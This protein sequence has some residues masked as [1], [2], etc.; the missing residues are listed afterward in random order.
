M[1]GKNQH[2]I[3]QSLLRGFSFPRSSKVDQLFVFWK[4]RSYPT[5][6]E[7]AAM[8][9]YFYSTLSTDGTE[10]LDDRITKYENSLASGLSELRK[11]TDQQPAPGAVVSEIIV[12]LTIRSAY[13]RDVFSV[14]YREVAARIDELSKDPSSWRKFIDIDGLELPASILSEIDSNL[15]AL[16][17]SLPITVPKHLLA[18]MTHAYLR[19]NFDRLFGG[20]GHLM[21]STMNHLLEQSRGM[22]RTGH[23]KALE[24]DLV[25]QQQQARLT[26]F[27]WFCVAPAGASF[28]LPDC[29]ALAKGRGDTSLHPFLMN[30]IDELEAVYFPIS[31]QQL[32]VGLIDDTP[33]YVP[34]EFNKMAAACSYRS[35]F[36]RSNEDDIRA[37]ATLIGSYV[38]ARIKP[39]ITESIKDLRVS[40]T[41]RTN[42]ATRSEESYDAA[43][44]LPSSLPIAFE[45]CDA[46]QNKERIAQTVGQIVHSCAQLFPLERLDQIVFRGDYSTIVE[47]YRLQTYQFNIRDDDGGAQHVHVNLAPKT[48]VEGAQRSFPIYPAELAAQL[49][50][51]EGD[52]PAHAAIYSIAFQLASASHREMLDK[53]FPGF[54][55]KAVD[56]Q[57]DA[58][59]QPIVE[60]TLTLYF[61]AR[62]CTTVLPAAVAGSAEACLAQLIEA[63]NQIPRLRREYFAVPDMQ[64]LLSSI[65]DHMSRVFEYSA[66]TLGHSR[67]AGTDLLSNNSLLESSFQS[68][69]LI[70]WIHVFA[71]DLEKAFQDRGQWKSSGDFLIFQQHIERILWIFGVIFWHEESGEPRVWI[72]PGP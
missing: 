45:Q 27:R 20:F 13:V 25:P 52:M 57:W 34:N 2:Y 67:S 49:D 58:A 54:L 40:D 38:D 48:S 36:C 1:A 9:S 55:W 15:E 56:D 64:R 44:S 59:L 66:L 32:I 7:D 10:T 70:D 28:V 35:F 33:P 68:L 5:S 51:Q 3:P 31:A 21:S 12:H 4:D 19:E 63:C 6:V 61:S 14:G 37:L 60:R 62:F 72:R 18:R 8:E 53:C 50:V 42:S 65:V 16:R 24:H 39:L 47:Q 43:V 26:S 22:L 69:G 29:V 11:L 23:A 17:A 71:Q 30:E 46:V 41:A